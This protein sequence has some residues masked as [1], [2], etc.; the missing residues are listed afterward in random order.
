M[1]VHKTILSAQS[2]A[3][4]SVQPIGGEVLTAGDR[5]EVEG[6]LEGQH[7]LRVPLTASAR[8]AP[9]SALSMVSVSVRPTNVVVQSVGGKVAVVVV[10]DMEE[11]A[12][13]VAEAM[14]VVIMEEEAIKLVLL[15]QLMQ[16]L[17]Q[18]EEVD[19]AM[20]EATKGVAGL[21][22]EVVDRVVVV[23]VMEASVPPT[24]TVLVML[25]S[26]ANTIFVEIQQ[27]MEITG[28]VEGEVLEQQDVEEE[29]VVEALGVEE[30]EETQEEDAIIAGEKNVTQF[31]NLLK[32]IRTIN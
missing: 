24:K 31:I 20:E 6:G 17:K 12:V 7:S 9:R 16:M 32:S 14:V 13:V 23:V 2:M 8:L 15:Y 18:V 26:V 29:E 25:L 30:V 28:R 3:S 4:A 10:G 1:T 19:M 22:M 27:H 5:E 11:V 21:A